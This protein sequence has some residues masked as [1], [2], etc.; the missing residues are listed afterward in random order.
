MIEKNIQT[1]IASKISKFDGKYLMRTIKEI[2]PGTVG[3]ELIGLLNYLSE[4]Q[5]TRKVKQVMDILTKQ[6]IQQLCDELGIDDSGTARQKK[7]GILRYYG[8]NK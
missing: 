1:D 4:R 8:I 6:Q 3:T 2:G 7:I 5:D